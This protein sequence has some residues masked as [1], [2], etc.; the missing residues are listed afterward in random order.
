MECRL[1][2]IWCVKS[3][4][5]RVMYP[6]WG[7]H[8]AAEGSNTRG[9]RAVSGGVVMEKDYTRDKGGKDGNGVRNE[10]VSTGR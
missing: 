8:R 1:L 4:Y 9:K 2:Y 7:T 6:D 3:T 10:E 5:V